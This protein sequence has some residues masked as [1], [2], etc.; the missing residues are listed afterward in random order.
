[1]IP[2]GVRVGEL[3]DALRPY[4]TYRVVAGAQ[5]LSRDIEHST[6]QRVGVGL[7]G[8][9]EHLDNDRV[10]MLGR[11]EIGYL[12][13]RATDERTAVLTALLEVGFP[14]LVITANGKIP[15]ELKAGAKA[16]PCALI[17]TTDVSTVATTRINAAL[18]DQ[19]TP[20][21]SQHGVLVDVF[22]VGVLMI[23][24]SGIGKSE[25]GLELVADGHRLVSDDIVLLEQQSPHV[26]MGS[27][28]ELT[29]HHMEIRGLGILNIRHLFGAAA[30]RT[31][32]RVE[33]VCELEAWNPETEYERLGLDERTI[34]LAGVPV[35]HL[36]VPV[37][38]GRSLKRILEVAA[39]D[40]LLKGQGTHSAQAFTER[41]RA[42]LK[43]RRPPV[44]RHRLSPQEADLE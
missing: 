8:Y 14:A 37:R 9:V 43:S 24:K 15:P 41:L 18:H 13:S 21:A 17:A 32:K 19:L 38:P 33:L 20:R 1:M 5:A 44:E 6:I 29:Q 26:V 2:G 12:W 30:V 39:R 16:A 35:P 27:S 10:Q 7:T 3:L 11:S 22:G 40:R 25:V 4:S 23:G 36:I 28:P 34:Q 31:R 42:L